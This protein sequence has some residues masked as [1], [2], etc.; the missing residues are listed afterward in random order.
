MKCNVVSVVIAS[1]CRIVRVLKKLLD[2]KER[3]DMP[4]HHDGYY[5]CGCGELV[6]NG[7]FCID[8][9]LARDLFEEGNIDV[10][11]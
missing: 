1:D 8:C 6:P 4:I 7:E 11:N 2:D 10:E 3:R 9:D 5:R